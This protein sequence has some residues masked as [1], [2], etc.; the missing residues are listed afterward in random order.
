LRLLEYADAHGRHPRRRTDRRRHRAA[1]KALDIRQ[2]GALGRVDVEL[3]AAADPLDAA[4]AD[5]IV[6]ADPVADPAW[7]GEAGLALLSRFVRAGLAGPFVLAA[8]EHVVLLERAVAEAKVPADRILGSAGAAIAGAVRALVGLEASAAAADVSV[9]V[10]GRPPGFSIAWSSAVVAGALVTERVAPHRLAAIA[11]GLP[12]LW[13]PG[14]QAIAAATAGM[15]EALATR[16]RRVH[17]AM[18]VGDG[19]IGRRGA[20]AML[21]CMLGEGRV[22]ARAVPSLSPQERTELQNALA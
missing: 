15:A 20:A 8:A 2:A 13:P 12:K 10:V 11:H 7:D 1:G 19:D 3:H 9:A 14:P 17:F 5:V 6:L 21:P 4:G 16:G 18:T 22:L